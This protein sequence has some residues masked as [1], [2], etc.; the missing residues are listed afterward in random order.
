MSLTAIKNKVTSTMGRQVLVTK[1]HSPTLLFAVGVAGVVTTVVLASRATL[2]MEEVLAEAE[3]NKVEIGDALALETDEYNENDATQDHAVNR[4]QTA[5]KIVRLYAPAVAVGVVSVACLTGSHYILTKRNIALTAAY[6][7]VD[8]AFKEYRSRVIDELG[9]EKDDEFRY[10]TVEKQVTVQTDDG[11]KTKT[12]RVADKKGDI[13]T[14]LFAE[15]TSKNWQRQASYNSMFLNSQ[16]NYMNDLLTARGHVFLNEVLDALG[17]ERTKA[18]AIT[19][20]VKGNGDSFV[21][22]GIMRDLA[23]AKEFIDGDEN[24]IWLEFNVDGPI[25]DKI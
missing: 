11:P 8:K 23:R 10:G 12:I 9:Q 4:V 19:G 3:K 16:Q 1:K 22:F 5:V 18:G 25:Y 7:G 14:F 24:A 17:L 13:Y 21:D 2:K 15:E 20:W 6:A